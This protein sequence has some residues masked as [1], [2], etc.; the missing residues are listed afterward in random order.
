MIRQ[1]S[2]LACAGSAG[3]TLAAV[4]AFG[5]LGAANLAAQA[6]P[7][8]AQDGFGTIK[9]RL[10]WGGAEAPKPVL[11]KPDKDTQVCGKRPLYDVELV[12]DPETKGVA[13]AFAFLP[14]PVGK[15]A[16]LESELKTQKV[17]I[18]QKDC[19]FDPPSVALHKDQTIVF[20][21]SDPVG[22]NIH[23]TG[24][25]N[26]AN[27]A[28]GPNGTAE[29]KLAYEK[30]PINLA[31]D[32]HPWMK[33]NLLVMNHPFFAVTGKDGAFEIQGVPAGEQHLIVWQRKAGFVTPGA[34]KG[35][36]VTVKAG[37]VTDIGEVKLDPAKIK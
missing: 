2:V 21:S 26:N 28:M 37:E 13:Y 30:R 4:V 35:Q 36:A 1:R 16:Q 14:S 31:C 3:A 7:P 34:S 29:K 18:D 20:K 23:Y 8:G 15:N 10:V 6:G 17:E 11:L 5:V 27:F 9:G 19:E 25:T 32:I 24:F 12:V 22:H 33:G